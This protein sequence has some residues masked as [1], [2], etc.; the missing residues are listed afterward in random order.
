MTNDLFKCANHSSRFGE[1]LAEQTEAL[2]MRAGKVP[3]SWLLA[4]WTGCETAP[5]YHFTKHT[6]GLHAGSH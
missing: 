5:L 6:S 4:D 1:N 3:P 2:I